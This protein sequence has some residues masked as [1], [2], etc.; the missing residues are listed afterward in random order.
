MPI[1]GEHFTPVT[2]TTTTTTISTRTKS[3]SDD[4]D[5]QRTKTL[6]SDNI[7]DTEP[8]TLDDTIMTGA[9][10][11]G[12]STEQDA[13]GDGE[14]GDDDGNGEGADDKSGLPVDSHGLPVKKSVAQIMKDKKRQTQLTL[15]W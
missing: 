14:E 12:K 1:E 4:G 7:M 3:Y 2:G 10:N 11:N 9:D 13:N 8:L 15:Q 6:S 5:H